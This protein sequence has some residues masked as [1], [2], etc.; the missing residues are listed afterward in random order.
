MAKQ[1]IQ[2]SPKMAKLTDLFVGGMLS[3]FLLFPGFHGYQQITRQKAVLFFLLTGGYILGALLLRLEDALAGKRQKKPLPPL[4]LTEK[5]VL[6]YWLLTAVSALLSPYPKTAF[7]GG[8]RLEGLVTISLYCACCLLVSRHCRPK[9]WMLWLFAGAVSLNCLLAALQLLG[10]NP[11]G[12]YPAGMNYYDGFKLYAGQFLGT[13]GNVDMLSALL[14]VA[15]PV[16]AVGAL[17]LRDRRRFL[18]LIPL[19]LS[20]L[21]L[22]WAFVSGGVLSVILSAVLCAPVLA[23][24]GRLRKILALLTAAVLLLGLVGVYTV[25]DRVGGFV[26]EAHQVLHGN[27]E[28]GFGSG[29]IYIWRKALELVDGHLL[30]GSGPDTMMLRT[31]AVFERYDQ[32]LGTTIR[33]LVD[34]AHNEYLNVLVHQGLPALLCFVGAIAAALAL[35]VKR[36]PADPV[37]ALCGAGVLCYGIQAFFGISSFLSA[38]YFWLSLAILCAA[39]TE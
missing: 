36:A 25:G 33:S 13:V 3:V 27:A 34:T 30:L 21:V 20:L 19:A 35:W 38:P 15:I 4:G 10:Y 9:G 7:L 1:K 24:N 32:R 37:S 28:D 14:C 8:A 31:D 39:Q 17:K 23:E 12:L 6:G 22:F 16:F 5:L 11:L 2:H 29:R 26:Y 18:L